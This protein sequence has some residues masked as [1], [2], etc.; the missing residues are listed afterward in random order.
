MRLPIVALAAFAALLTTPV[1][2][3]QPR[4]GSS[5]P[6][7]P[8]AAPTT[9]PPPIVY[10]FPPLMTPPAGGLTPPVPQNAPPPRSR[11]RSPYGSGGFYGPVLGYAETAPTSEERAPQ[12]RASGW[13]RLAVTP[14]NAQ[15]FVDAYYVG[16]VDDVNAKRELQLEAGPHRLKL[17]A[18]QH[19]TLAVDVQIAINETLTYRGALEPAPPLPPA[20]RT[21]GASTPMYLIPNC[22][23]GNVPPRANRLPSGCDIKHVQVLGAR[24]TSRSQAAIAR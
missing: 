8:P 23:L 24:N 22:Y 17:I 5:R 13:L 10:P 15:V 12:A 1:A 21:A 20:P 19:E 3:A 16:T 7:P 18:P 2:Q 14:T 9:V 11:Q 4:H 6:A